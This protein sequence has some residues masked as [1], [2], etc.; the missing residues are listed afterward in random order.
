MYLSGH[1]TPHVY[2][3]QHISCCRANFQESASPER[4]TQ[5]GRL[6]AI[7]SLE[8]L[9]RE[10]LRGRSFVR[11]SQVR[12][13]FSITPFRNRAQNCARSI[14]YVYSLDFVLTSQL[15]KRGGALIERHSVVGP[16]IQS[17]TCHETHWRSFSIPR[18][19]SIPY[20]HI[21]GSFVTLI[22][23]QGDKNT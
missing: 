15:V 18:M 22:P 9:H 10:P 1:L 4:Y 17:G 19:Y 21:S 13:I 3:V 11:S 16:S 14:R 20:S 23:H 12:R 7:A 8:I 2:P 5:N 6:S